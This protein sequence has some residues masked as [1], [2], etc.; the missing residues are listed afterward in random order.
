MEWKK[1]KYLFW[2]VKLKGGVTF[3][4]R[5]CYNERMLKNDPEL[6]Y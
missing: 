2:V 6:Q 1:R 5:T 4:Q 3:V